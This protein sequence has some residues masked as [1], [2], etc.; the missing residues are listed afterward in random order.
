[1]D[2]YLLILEDL[3]LAFQLQ[4]FRRKAKRDLITH[5]KFYF[6]DSGVYYLIRPKNLFDVESE[7][8]GAA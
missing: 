1:M 6:F 8:E 4:V 5:S 7:K 2:S 3:L